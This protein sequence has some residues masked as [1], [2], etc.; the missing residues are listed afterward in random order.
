MRINKNLCNKC[1]ECI[2]ECP[3][4]AIKKDDT[5]EYIIDSELCNDCKDFCD[6]ECIRVCE[7]NAMI[8]NDGTLPEFDPTRRLRSEHLIWLMAILGSRG[9]KNGTFP[10]GRGEWD[11]FRRL[12]S[13]MYLNPDM[14]IRLTSDFDDNCTKCARKQQSGHA[15][16]LR[17]F[18]YACF[19]ELGVEPGC[20]MK[21]WDAV[22]LAEEKFSLSFIENLGP[23]SDIVL[24]DY[25]AFLSPEAFT[26]IVIS[27]CSRHKHPGGA[28]GEKL[29]DPSLK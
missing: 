25:I 9:N 16:E 17:V 14:M 13:D 3:F 18:D 23:I 21:L 26:K 22:Q 1:G 4:K 12:I 11:A 7:S 19:K 29:N 6:I 27:R 28:V 24:K 20:V 10:V 8:F 15:E 5:S 2:T